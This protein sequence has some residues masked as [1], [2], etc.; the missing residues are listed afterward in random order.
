MRQSKIEDRASRMARSRIGVSILYLLSSILIV[1]SGCG[2][3]G[4]VGKEFKPQATEV[5]KFD[6]KEWAT[7]LSKVVTPDGYVRHEQIKNNDAG[8]RDA[9]FRYVGLIGEVSPENKPELFPTDKDKLAYYLNAYNALC[10]YA[11][12]KRDYPP[13]L[14]KTLPPY[15]V[16]FFDKFP[17]GG[18]EMNLDSIEK[19]YVRSV[20]DPRIHFAL[21]C[22]SHSCP[23]LRAEPYEGSKLD[24]QLDDQGRIY[25]SDERGVVKKDNETVKL[26]EIFAKFY[27]DEWIDAY[28]KK[29]GKTDATLIEA[30]RPYAAKDSPVQTATKYEAMTYDWS[31]NKP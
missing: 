3:G 23:P 2:G 18:K 22:M 11:V 31:L 9:L 15:A 1:S 29:S 5:K 26:S 28:K 27:T 4:G 14:A 8:V 30:I 16:Y 12:Y 10:M 13:N 25:L 7:V 20:G 17:V 21:N 6:N 24:Q 19:T